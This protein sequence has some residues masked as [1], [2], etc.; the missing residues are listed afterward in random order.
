MGSAAFS[1]YVSVHLPGRRNRRLGEPERASPEPRARPLVRSRTF[2]KGL[3][4]HRVLRKAENQFKLSAG[5]AASRVAEG[6]QQ[7]AAGATGKKK[8]EH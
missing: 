1:G 7:K 6:G 5:R 8:R 2:A 4:A 3:W